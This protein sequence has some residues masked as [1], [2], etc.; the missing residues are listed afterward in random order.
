MKQTDYLLDTSERM[1]LFIPL[2]NLYGGNRLILLQSVWKDKIYRVER[3]QGMNKDIKQMQLNILYLSLLYGSG[4]VRVATDS[5]AEKENFFDS[6]LLVVCLNEQA[7]YERKIT[8]VSDDAFVR[9]KARAHD[10][11]C[12]E[13]PVY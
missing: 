5:V 4:K 8:L 10:I 9:V 6:Q 13:P 3:R 12:I 1:E 7:K 2:L 11:D